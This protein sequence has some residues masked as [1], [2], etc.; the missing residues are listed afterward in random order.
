MDVDPSK[1]HCTRVERKAAD[2]WH[3]ARSMM[4]NETEIIKHDSKPLQLPI[5]GFLKGRYLY[6]IPVHLLLHG[7]NR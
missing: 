1:E 5:R 3:C 4:L 2:T 6:I 7:S